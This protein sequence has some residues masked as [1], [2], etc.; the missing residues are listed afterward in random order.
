MIDLDIVLPCYQPP[1]H[2]HKGLIKTYEALTKQ[3]KLQF[4]LVLDGCPRSRIQSELKEIL[5]QNVP[6]RLIELNQ[7]YEIKFTKE[8]FD[9]NLQKIFDVYYESVLPIEENYY[10]YFK[11]FMNVIEGFYKSYILQFPNDKILDL[12]ACQNTTVYLIPKKDIPRFLDIDDM[13]KFYLKLY[14]I[15]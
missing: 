4:I 1:L 13:Y 7:N 3:Y 6:L 11:E 15:Q 8:D 14:F 10:D 2:W 5:Q 9:K 12:D